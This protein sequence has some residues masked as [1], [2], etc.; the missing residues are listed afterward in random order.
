M[1]AKAI[2]SPAPLPEDPRSPELERLLTVDPYVVLPK[3]KKEE[4]KKTRAKNLAIRKKISDAPME[5]YQSSPSVSITDEEVEEEE[6]REAQS[7]Q[8][9]K[10]SASE[11]AEEVDPP[12]TFKHLRKAHAAPTGQTSA[13]MEPICSSSSEDDRHPREHSAAGR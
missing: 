11:D 10:R 7:S 9:G 1:R 12:R 6:E 5:S 2:K 3:T 13:P 4:G 8:G